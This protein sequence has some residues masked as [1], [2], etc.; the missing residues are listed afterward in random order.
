MLIAR[1]R[2]YPVEASAV[3]EVADGKKMRGA[4]SKVDGGDERLACNRAPP[5]PRTGFAGLDRHGDRTL[6]A[7]RCPCRLF[8][9]RER[10]NQQVAGAMRYCQAILPSAALSA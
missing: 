5:S 1:G 10:A 3:N 2:I 9:V 8:R 4:M 6:A 7:H